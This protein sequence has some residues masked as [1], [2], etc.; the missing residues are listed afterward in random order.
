MISSPPRLENLSWR[1]LRIRG[2]G[3]KEL[4]LPTP[5]PRPYAAYDSS[6]TNLGHTLGP[7]DLEIASGESRQLGACKISNLEMAFKE[8]RKEALGIE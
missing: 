2:G 1:S 7:I 4:I 5:Q 3:L 6:S 8:R